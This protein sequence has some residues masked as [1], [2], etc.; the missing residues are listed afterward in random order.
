MCRGKHANNKD[1][2]Q[3]IMNE[4]HFH[5]KLPF[6]EKFKKLFEN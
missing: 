1:K 4:G 6:F 2:I 3:P 5:I